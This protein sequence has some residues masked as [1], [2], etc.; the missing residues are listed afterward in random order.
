MIP[1]PP[2]PRHNLRY[3]PDPD[4]PELGE[5][6]LHCEQNMDQFARAYAQLVLDELT[7]RFTELYSPNDSFP[8]EDV[9]SV[10]TKLKRDI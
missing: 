2:K 4:F 9:H 8:V 1:F 3:G 10:I 7:K 5:H 6:F